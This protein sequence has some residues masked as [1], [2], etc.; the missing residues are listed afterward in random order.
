MT[1]IMNQSSLIAVEASAGT[2]KTFEL[3]QRFVGLLLNPAYAAADAAPLRGILALTFTKKATVEMKERIVD[4][5]R[6]M[7]FD[8]FNT[9]E[10]STAMFA[11]TGLPRGEA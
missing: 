8:A 4:S 6:R 7:A 9:V 3:A 1:N 11:A 5:V 10:E 2:G